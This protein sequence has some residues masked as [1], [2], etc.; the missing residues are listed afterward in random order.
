MDLPS[1]RHWQAQ[2]PDTRPDLHLA[3]GFLA[4]AVVSLEPMPDNHWVDAI[5]G[6]LSTQ[7]VSRDLIETRAR[8]EL[9]SRL[10][11]ARAHMATPD[12]RYTP[13]LAVRADGEFDLTA[14]S[15]GFYEAI[16][17]DLDMWQYLLAGQR[18]GGLLALLGSHSVGE[19]GEAARGYIA[20]HPEAQTL[21][22]V[23][24]RSWEVLSR[25]LCTMY[26]KRSQIIEGETPAAG[27]SAAYRAGS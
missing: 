3:D 14:W 16:A 2:A 23:A 22:E 25:L 18:E 24:K 7:T 19:M 10:V 8:K 9:L 13:I 26:E 17:D 5:M 4:G 27:Q 11:Q 15:S 12:P 6:P 1:Y 20:S 21:S